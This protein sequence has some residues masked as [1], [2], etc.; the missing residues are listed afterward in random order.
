[1]KPSDENL[2]LMIKQACLK[3]EI[4]E[5]DKEQ[6]GFIKTMHADRFDWFESDPMKRMFDA[7]ENGAPV[8]YSAPNMVENIEDAKD[9]DLT[10]MDCV[11]HGDMEYWVPF[12]AFE[13]FNDD[14]S[15][16]FKTEDGKEIEPVLVRPIP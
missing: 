11:H 15:L 16:S 7:V 10:D 5:I 2:N 4:K 9:V 14:G 13:Q 8:R 3:A 6:Q 1:M 12:E